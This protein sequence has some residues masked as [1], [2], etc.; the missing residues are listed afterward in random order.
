MKRSRVGPILSSVAVAV[1]LM[2]MVGGHAS[3]SVKPRVAT[4]TLWVA[5]A[6]GRSTLPAG[7]Q[8]AAYTDINAAISAAVAGDT[9]VVCPGTY[10]GSVTITTSSTVQPTITTGVEINKS[11]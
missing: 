1:G 11:I 3:A 9:V 10:T 5:P 6:T 7:C 4:T 8:T 2:T